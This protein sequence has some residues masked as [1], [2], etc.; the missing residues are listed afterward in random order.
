M[1]GAKETWV[2]RGGLEEKAGDRQNVTSPRRDA[3]LQTA[4][5]LVASRAPAPGFVWLGS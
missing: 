2:V 1:E 3:C 4:T 5:L